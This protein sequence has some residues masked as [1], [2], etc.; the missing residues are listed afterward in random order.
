M[1]RT[2]IAISLILVETLREVELG[3]APFVPNRLILHAYGILMTHRG[4]PACYA[5]EACGSELATKPSTDRNSRLFSTSEFL[6]H[7]SSQALCF[8]VIF[9]RSLLV[10]LGA[11]R[12][13][14]IDESVGIVWLQQCGSI[15]PKIELGRTNLEFI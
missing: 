9:V 12:V 8:L 6:D 10:A 3:R 2:S 14:T 13:S 7:T 4:K 15:G 5:P 1:A 11:S